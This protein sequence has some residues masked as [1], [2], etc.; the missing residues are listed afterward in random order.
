M[1]NNPYVSIDRVLD[2]SAGQ[3]KIVDFLHQKTFTNID[4]N[5]TR[6]AA[7]SSEEISEGNYFVDI[8]ENELTF[9]SSF[10]L[11]ETHIPV[12]ILSTDE[13]LT[14]D[15]DNFPT[16]KTMNNGTNVVIRLYATAAPLSI[17]VNKITI[18]VILLTEVK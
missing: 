10:T 18:P 9:D 7:T 11:K 2:T 14:L 1:S 15:K 4:V 16:C 6:F 3:R 13:N 12:V 5:L 8:E 17:V